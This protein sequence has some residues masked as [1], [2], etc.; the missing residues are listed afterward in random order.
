MKRIFGVVVVSAVL[1]VS[2]CGGDY[3]RA[4]NAIWAPPKTAEPLQEASPTESAVEEAET[5]SPEPE[6]EPEP[7]E[8][9]DPANV[10]KVLLENN[11]VDSFNELSDTSP[12]QAITEIENVGP[13][14]IRVHVQ[15]P[16]TDGEKEETARWV[17]HMACEENPDMA[18]VVIRDASGIDENF[19]SAR[20]N[21][22]PAC[23]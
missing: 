3:E 2:A 4:W 13:T 21:I 23:Q 16:L 6:H 19:Y 15:E 14:G 8:S 22:L 7:T 9:V 12:G 10:E 5:E 20:L 1:L 11:V 17:M 18:V